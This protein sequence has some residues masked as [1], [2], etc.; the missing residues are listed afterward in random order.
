M[1][2]H[3][4]K[5]YLA[6]ALSSLFAAGVAS[7]AIAA[8]IRMV[9]SDS[10]LQE[11]SLTPL[12]YIEGPIEGGDA[13]RVRQLMTG[14]PEGSESFLMVALNSPGGDLAE[15]LKIARILQT[16]NLQVVTDVLDRNGDP[17]DCASS[18]V[19]IYLG[20]GYRYLA[21]S[22]RLG[23]H[24]F[25]Y[26][27]DDIA[28]RSETTRDVQL[29]SA[30]ITDLISAAYVD[31][32]FFSLMGRTEADDIH[33]VDP[34]LLEKFNVVNR[35]VAFQASEFDLQKGVLKHVMTRAGLFGRNLVTTQCVDGQVQF[36][37]AIG[38]SDPMTFE[39]PLDQPG[40]LDKALQFE[41]MI[42]RYEAHAELT[43]EQTYRDQFVQTS[44]TMAP[45]QL[46]T[47]LSA[48]LLDL[49]LV[50]DNGVFLGTTF[51]LGDGKMGDMIESCVEIAPSDPASLGGDQDLEEPLSPVLIAVTMSVAPGTAP[52]SPTLP[53]ASFEELAMDMYDDYLQAWSQPNPN[54]MSYMSSIYND[55][56][57]FYDT[58]MAK[59]QLIEEK[60]AFAER[61]P[62]REY[63]ARHDTFEISC[64]GGTCLVAGIIDWNAE[65]PARGKSASGVAYYG[66]GFDMETGQIFFENGESRKR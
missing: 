56:I 60:W 4:F 12:I 11:T 36:L 65:S 28:R 25:R 1:N 7:S 6:S 50:A 52:S 35:D 18:C 64:T 37:S 23:V 5:K 58:E 27:V 9:L 44:F 51:Q 14:L 49:R 38:V 41:V 31:P 63:T 2:R 34:L 13:E 30:E 40:V 8:D 66:L 48:S 20:G 61:W 32:A 54:A 47:I 26:V 59:P 24:Q 46:A 17:A 33:W 22:S 21:E 55:I 19:L 57:D 16:A 15:G 10:W 62:L 42:D 45:E 43:A 29:T 53:I 39:G 3:M